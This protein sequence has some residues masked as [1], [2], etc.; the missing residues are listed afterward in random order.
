[1]RVATSKSR[2]EGLKHEPPAF[3]VELRVVA[4]SKSRT[5][6]WKRP[7]RERAAEA[8]MTGM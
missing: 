8:A 5:E 2:T 6:G 1:M 4:T 3:V 7:R